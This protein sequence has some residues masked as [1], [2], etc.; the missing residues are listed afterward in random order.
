MEELHASYILTD[1]GEQIYVHA[2]GEGT[3]LICCNGAG[4]STFF[5]SYLV[6]HFK[7]DHRV[8]LWDYRGHGRSSLPQ[9][10]PS[11]DL[12]IERFA[13]DLRLVI[14][15]LELAEPVILVGHSM[16][17]QVILEYA[18]RH[19]NEVRA[20]V[21][22]LGT[23]ARP[24]DTLL[25]SPLSKPIFDLVKRTGIAMGKGGRRWFRPLVG[26]P[27]AFDLA[28]RAGLVDRH[29]ANR[30]DLEMY[31]DH[32]NQ[33][34]PEVLFRTIELIAEHDLTDRLPSIQVPT[35]VVA[36]ENDLFTPMQCSEK[37]VELLPD[38]ELFVLAQGSH[39]AL[40]EHPETIHLRLERFFAEALQRP[41]D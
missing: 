35:L 10:P 22:M 20:L 25:D 34:D 41:K 15:A 12:S 36:A 40:V 27:W 29:Y 21:P 16:G 31:L 2:V 26:A 13:S 37:M 11:A 17:C 19:P 33:M 24:L 6:D 14:E 28:R 18:A 32:L 3:P 7:R 23:Y 1:D 38:A 9:D 5:W 39:A 4:V 30:Q 8:I